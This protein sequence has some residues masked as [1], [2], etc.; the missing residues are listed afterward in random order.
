MPVCTAPGRRVQGAVCA[1]QSAVLRN[2]PMHRPRGHRGRACAA[3]SSL[4]EHIEALGAGLHAQACSARE[5]EPATCGKGTLRSAA[6]VWC[7]LLFELPAVVCPTDCMPVLA[8]APHR[9]DAA[10]NG[11]LAGGTLS[12]SRCNSVDGWSEG[13]PRELH[14]RDQPRDLASDVAGARAL[15]FLGDSQACSAHTPPAVGARRGPQAVISPRDPEEQGSR[16][17]A[18]YR[19][20][21][22]PQPPPQRM[23]ELASGCS[24]LPR[25]FLLRSELAGL[26]E[27]LV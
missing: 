27:P 9:G 15:L 8:A 10:G 16:S 19:P 11:R 14:L 22:Q 5:G 3:P 17:I 20:W 13:N 7:E 24:V 12:S 23:M 1:G 21:G 4:S 2:G 25:G 26:A 18:G 6:L